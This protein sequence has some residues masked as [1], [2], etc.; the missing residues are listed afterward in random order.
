[1]LNT[2]DIDLALQTGINRY[3]G[4]LLH[5]ILMEK[6]DTDYAEELHHNEL[7]PFSQ[8]LFRDYQK[9]CYVWRISTL[10]AEAKE[11]IIQRLLVDNAP[12]IVLK[13][14]NARINILGKRLA[15]PLTYQTLTNQVLAGESNRRIVLRFLTPTTFKSAGEFVVFP[16]V[17]LIYGSLFRKW[18]AFATAVSLNDTAAQEHLVRHTKIAGYK[19]RTVRYAME[20]VFINAFLGEVCLYVNGPEALSQ[21]ADILFAFVRYTGLGAKT[22]LGMGGIDAE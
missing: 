20:G 6:L 13:H 3:S 18:N 19:L 21:I 14:N 17:R 12:E 4:S 10:T 15:N 16:E 11:N 5:G 9:D 22:A 2:L 8:F 7:Q 1:M